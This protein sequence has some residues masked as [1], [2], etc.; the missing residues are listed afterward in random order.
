MSRIMHWHQNVKDP[1]VARRLTPIRHGLTILLVLGVVLAGVG[2]R[3][4]S[5]DPK[6]ARGRYLA[7]DVAMCVQCHTPRTDDGRL[8]KSKLFEGA[9]VPVPAPANVPP[10]QWA[11]R[12]PN[13]AGLTGVTDADEIQ[14]LT[15]GRRP[16]RPAPLAPMPPFRL[17]REDAE[18]IVAYLR[19][20]GRE[21]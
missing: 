9:P 17:T 15:T 8:D 11:T 1:G 7:N 18:A 14:L 20:I 3:P 19:T 16:A 2:A 10:A 6:V 4:H 12:A 5:R 21:R 13:I